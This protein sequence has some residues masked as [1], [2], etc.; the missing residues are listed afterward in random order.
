[1]HVWQDSC[2]GQLTSGQASLTYGN[3]TQ[4]LCLRLY[5]FSLKVVLRKSDLSWW[6][7]EPYRVSA[8][9]MRVKCMVCFLE[10]WWYEVE[11]MYRCA[12]AGV[13]TENQ[14]IGSFQVTEHNLQSVQVNPVMSIPGSVS[15]HGL[16]L[17]K[18]LDCYVETARHC[19]YSVFLKDWTG[20]LRKKS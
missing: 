5:Q 3:N 20:T 10:W 12:W 7:F 2:W 14:L 16:L 4:Q 9:W 8:L 11:S 1:M 17:D 13:L 18:Q 6:L 19:S 15:E